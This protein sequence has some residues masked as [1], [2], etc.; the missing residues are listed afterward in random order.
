MRTFLVM[1]LGLMLSAGSVMA[2]APGSDV[3]SR[4]YMTT[5][6]IKDE[7]VYVRDAL[8]MA[9]ADRGI[10]INGVNHIGKM[11]HRTAAATGGTKKVFKIAEAYNFCSSILSRKMMEADPHNIA[12][13]PY[14]MTIYEL[15]DEPGVVYL[16][17]RKP[18]IVGNQKS[19]DALKEV[20]D[21]LDGIAKDVTGN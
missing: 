12:F 17:Y 14:I 9:I 15:N 10:K 20:G 13:C 6:V 4:N 8:K 7:F 2:G 3:K 21:L 5:H 16:S 11:L 18:L 19:R 1:V